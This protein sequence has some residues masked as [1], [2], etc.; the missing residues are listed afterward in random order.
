MRCAFRHAFTL[1]ELLVVIA[2]I[3]ILIALLVPAVQKVRE[4]AGRLQCQNNLKQIGL[5]LHNYHDVFRKLP[6]GYASSV[7]PSTN[8]DLGPGW[9]WAAHMLPYLEQ[10]NLH[11]QIEFSADIGAASNALARV[12]VLEILR[13]PAEMMA[14][15]TFVAAKTTIDI[16]FS[17]YIGMYGTGEVTNDPGNG[18]GVFYR[19][20][21]TRLTDISDGASNTIMVGERHARLALGAWAGAVTGAEVPPGMPSPLGPEGAPVLC[22]GHTGEAASG[23][24]PNNPTNHVDDFGSDHVTGAHFLF[25]DGSVHL[26]GNTVSPLVWEA[27]GTRAGNE[28]YSF[29][30]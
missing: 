14:P 12:Q 19:N 9:G 28:P 15:P 2:I 23:H 11:K 29:G 25:A 26:I 16:A 8:A 30:Q 24:T 22:L 6:P 10:G 5:G 20:S 13:C 1:I 18:N 17:S 7:D 21:R 27:L 4:A 3:G